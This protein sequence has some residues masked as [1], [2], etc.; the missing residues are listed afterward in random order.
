MA[1]ITVG[2]FARR[3]SELHSA[4]TA[5][6]RYYVVPC[7]EP[8]RNLWRIRVGVLSRKSDKC[9]PIAEPAYGSES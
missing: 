3:P 8:R 1:V 6:T 4:S 9:S 7:L 2:E 5:G